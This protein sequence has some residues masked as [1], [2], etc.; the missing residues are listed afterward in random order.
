MT[1]ALNSVDAS[2]VKTLMEGM[3]SK[4]VCL[5]RIDQIFKIVDANGDG[6]ISRCEDVSFQV[7]MGNP[8]DYALKYS[9]KW[10]LSSA[11]LWCNMM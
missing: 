2:A 7:A 6:T 11:K 1:C 3:N 8:E 5:E 10:T 9:T 4:A